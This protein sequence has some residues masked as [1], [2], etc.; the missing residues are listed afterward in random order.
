[1]Q[2]SINP[3]LEETTKANNDSKINSSPRTMTKTSGSSHN[4]FFVV[5]L[6]ICRFWSFET[7]LTQTF[8]HRRKATRMVLI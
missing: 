8:T 6:L 3:R 2:A 4:K 5:S 1:M 7:A